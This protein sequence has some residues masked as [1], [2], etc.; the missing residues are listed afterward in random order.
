MAKNK[1]KLRNYAKKLLIISEENGSISHER[2]AAILEA[3]KLNPPRHIRSILR[4]YRAQIT[5]ALRKENAVI[6]HVGDISQDSIE[7]F[8]KQLNSYYKKNVLI[9]KKE[10]PDL[11]AGILIRAGD[12]IWDSSISGRLQTLAKSF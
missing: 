11:I 8:Q 1:H 3:L 2:V 9:T 7:T 5:Q 12:D 4:I 6:E 10:N